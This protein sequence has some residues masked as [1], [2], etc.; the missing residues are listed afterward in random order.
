MLF[1]ATLTD[2][3]V[4]LQAHLLANPVRIETDPE[5]MVTDLIKQIFYSVS[6]DDK[7]ALLLWILNNE[8][9]ERMLVFCNRKDSAEMLARALQRRSDSKRVAFRRCFPAEPPENSG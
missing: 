9:V 2:E 4:R 5:T 6:C 3:I 1:S 7:L 8:E